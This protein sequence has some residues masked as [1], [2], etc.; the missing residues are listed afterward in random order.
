MPQTPHT[1]PSPAN[2]TQQQSQAHTAFTAS[3]KAVGSNHETRLRERTKTLASNA[4][5][6]AAQEAR[7][8]ADTEALARQNREWEG[9]ADEA[10]RAL[11]ELGDLQNWAEVVEREF[12]V[13][14]EVLRGVEEGEDNCCDGEG[15]GEGDGVDGRMEDRVDGEVDG[16]LDGKGKG[17][18][19]ERA[20]GGG[21]GRW[22][23]WW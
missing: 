10:G 5:A 3:L 2:Q 17:K 12:L 22:F 11:K 4:D 16:D 18:E 20:S 15:E 13:L 9:V 7:L 23:K 19:R 21:Y 14:E 6:L 8:S 1:D